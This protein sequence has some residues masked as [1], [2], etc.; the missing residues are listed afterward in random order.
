MIGGDLYLATFD[1]D[2]A[3]AAKTHLVKPFEERYDVE[4]RLRSFP[5]D[6][7]QSK[8]I[9]SIPGRMDVTLCDGNMAVAAMELGALL[10]LRLE[11]IPNFGNQHVRFRK[12]AYDV[13]SGVAYFAA[14]V[15]GE[16]GIGYNTNYINVAPTTWEDFFR[17]ELHGRLS[18]AG[19]PNNMVMTAALMT[20]QD[21]N[22][23]TDLI[24]I[25]MTLMELKPQMRAYW[26]AGSEATHL[27]STGEVMMTNVYRGDANRLAA[28]GYPVKFVIPDEGAP[29]AF[30]CLV[31][32][33]N[34]GNRAA[35]EAFIDLALDA[36]I[37]NGYAL[38]GIG[39][40]PSTTNAILADE[41]KQW[42]GATRE[43]IEL[44]KFENCKYVLAN[45]TT[46]SEI[47]K[48]V[49]AG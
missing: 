7:E 19:L 13:G 29:A 8:R 5:C 40:A 26:Y 10:P 36:S 11:N 30:D 33:R 22:N 39:S 47:A 37:V 18:M 31:I 6:S 16:T 3:D 48:R 46:W 20:G 27:L 17:P 2:N 4:V 28:T 34:C 21:I 23:V 42:L 32:P 15:W 49:K 14:V 12:A 41:Q 38:H 45:Q 35:A 9:Q 24:A 25:E 1:R 44:A 43:R